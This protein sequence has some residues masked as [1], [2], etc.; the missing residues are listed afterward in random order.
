MRQFILCAAVPAL[1]GFLCSCSHGEVSAS[2]T[3]APA[4]TVESVPDLNLI[5]VA[6][7]ERF[8]GTTVAAP[9]EAEQLTANGVVAAD[10]SRN[11]GVNALSSGRVTEIHARLGDDVQKD[12]VLLRMTSP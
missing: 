6:E 5:S 1:S 3:P 12:Q 10:V 11:V 4:A 9:Q 2:A 8:A 7:P